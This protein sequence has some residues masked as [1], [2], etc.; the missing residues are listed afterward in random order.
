MVVTPEQFGAGDDE[1]VDNT[2]ALL[3]MFGAIS[4]DRKRSC[5][6]KLKRKYL[7]LATIEVLENNGCYW[8]FS[9]DSPGCSGF[10][11]C[12][13]A[14]LKAM[15]FRGIQCAVFENMSFDSGYLA[16]CVHFSEKNLGQ[17]TD[18]SWNQI[19]S[20]N[21]KFKNV[22]HL[23]PLAKVGDSVRVGCD[24]TGFPLQSSEYRWH[25]AEFSGN[26]PNPGG[27]AIRIMG[28]FNTKNFDVYDSIF[29][30]Y[31][32]GFYQPT[33]S[34]ETRIKGGTASNLGRNVLGCAVVAG[35]EVVHVEGLKMENGNPGFAAR[36]VQSM[37]AGTIL[38]MTGGSYIGTPGPD[39]YMIVA[40]GDLNMEGVSLGR[41]SR[42]GANNL[43]VQANGAAGIRVNNCRMPNNEGGVSLSYP[44]VYDGSHNPIF[45]DGFS[46][47]FEATAT[48]KASGNRTGPAD[49]NMRLF[50][51]YSSRDDARLR[52]SIDTTSIPVGS[53]YVLEGDTYSITVPFTAF[54]TVL[55]F[56]SI[57]VGFANYGSCLIRALS[58]VTLA[59]TWQ[60]GFS[61]ALTLAV[62]LEN[63]DDSGLVRNHSVDTIGTHGFSPSDVGLLLMPGVNGECLVPSGGKFMMAKLSSSNSVLNRITGGSVTLRFTLSSW[64]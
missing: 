17:N 15:H 63:I 61:G 32:F 44:P 4:G 28:G 46:R 20:F 10:V 60:P 51:N 45:G 40:A 34:G 11:Y 39:D 12:G 19:A 64:K 54:A 56:R 25:G 62:G 3:D 5:K 42:P 16:S 23:R 13:P 49:G 33:G 43:K 29:E 50:Q 53:T 18:G 21:V 41:N 2:Q 38:N 7:H 48:A 6:I 26:G 36:A 37:G 22:K 47:G 27:A 35:G 30:D 59:P 9:G 1:R 57:R 52:G 58:E 55:G 31:D 24:W 14:G 8:R